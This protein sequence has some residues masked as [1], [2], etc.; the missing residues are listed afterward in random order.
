MKLNELL[1]EVKGDIR[2]YEWIPGAD[3]GIQQEPF[4][5]LYVG[6]A[7]TVPAE[8]LRREIG[9]IHGGLRS[10]EKG[11]VNIQLENEPG[12]GGGAT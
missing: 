10:N 12:E 7:K 5:E 11:M 2:I 9:Y 8:L 3:T 4:R 1:K 6:C